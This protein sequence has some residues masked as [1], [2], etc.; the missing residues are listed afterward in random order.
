M[1]GYF[2]KKISDFYYLK[3][4][5]CVILINESACPKIHMVKPLTFS[6]IVF[7]NYFERQLGLMRS[8]G[9]GPVLN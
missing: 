3:E 8:C 4:K 6:I 1:L 9:R 2:F 7:E 5:I